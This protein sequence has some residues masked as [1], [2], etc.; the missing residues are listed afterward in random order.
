MVRTARGTG[1]AKKTK[2][3]SA[4]PGKIKERIGDRK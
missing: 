3:G 2:M 1:S 4:V